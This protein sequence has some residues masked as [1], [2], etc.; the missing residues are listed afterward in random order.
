MW[1]AARSSRGTKK[2]FEHLEHSSRNRVDSR[3]F[4]ALD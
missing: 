4:L 2:L 3:A 1:V